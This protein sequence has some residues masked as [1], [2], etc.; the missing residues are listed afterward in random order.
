MGQVK[1][2]INPKS[3]G[4]GIIFVSLNRKKRLKQKSWELSINFGKPEEEESKISYNS[5]LVS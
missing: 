5:E 4:L 3:C 1:K 2:G